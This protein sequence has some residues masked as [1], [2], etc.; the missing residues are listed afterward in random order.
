MRRAY[1]A[2]AVAGKYLYIDGGELSYRSSDP[3]TTAYQYSSTILSID[4]S[5][6]WVNQTIVFHSTNKPPSAPDLSVTSLWYDEDNNI[7]Y[8]GFTGRASDF[9]DS[10]ET[11]PLSLWSF[12]PDGTGSGSW[13]EEIGTADPAWNHLTRPCSGYTAAGS[14]RALVLGGV[15]QNQLLPGI[16][17]FD[18]TTKEF[19]NKTATGFNPGG[20][21]VS[22]QM[23]YVPSFGP[24]GLFLL[25]GGSLGGDETTNIRFDNI[26]V[27]DAETNQ[28]FLYGGSSSNLGSAAIPFDE[29]YIL[30]LPAFYWF[31]V[32]Y[33]PQHPRQGHSCNAVGGSQILSIGGVDSNSKISIGNILDIKKSTFNSS[34]DPFT[35][36]LGIFDMTSLKWADHYRANAPAYVQSDLVKSFYSQNPQNGSQLSSSGLR[37]MFQTTHFTQPS[38]STSNLPTTPETSSSLSNTGAIVGEVVGGAVGIALVA[39]IAFLLYRRKQRQHGAMSKAGTSMPSLPEADQPAEFCPLEKRHE[40]Y[41]EPVGPAEVEDA[42][43]EMGED[44]VR[45]EID[46]NEVFSPRM[47]Q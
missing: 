1:H 32:D 47:G 16:V 9:G 24:N 13:K 12:R 20:S 17:H 6:D 37:N 33:P 45:P 18:M 31:K 30:T 21:A 29:I 2:S 42:R 19:A 8:T 5:Q 28:C 40:L 41:P 11:P 34:A 22:G 7:F 44:E 10:P 26:W 4:L 25:M 23:Q 36:G 15:A 35:Q 43:P 3:D 27:Y 38:P 46:G 14:H 39:G